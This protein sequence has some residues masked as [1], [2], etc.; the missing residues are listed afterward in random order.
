MP[1]EQMHTLAGG[2]RGGGGWGNKKN[3]YP[4]L[5]PYLKTSTLGK[6]AK[7]SFLPSIPLAQLKTLDVT[8]KA[9][10]GEF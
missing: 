8:Y 2:G 9:N 7:K 10:I 4:R 1:T 6:M 3:F 5:M